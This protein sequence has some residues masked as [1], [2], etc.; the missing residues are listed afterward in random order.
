[1]DERPRAETIKLLEE[2]PGI[3]ICESGFGMVS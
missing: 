2:K 1:M 3:N